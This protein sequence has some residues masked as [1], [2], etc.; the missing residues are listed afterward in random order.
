MR[1]GVIHLQ[2]QYIL[3][4]SVRFDGD[5]NNVNLRTFIASRN[6]QHQE[7]QGIL[8]I[9]QCQETESLPQAGNCQTTNIQ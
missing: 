9:I 1:C 3:E 6:T 4:S 2:I 7:E 5:T 8:S